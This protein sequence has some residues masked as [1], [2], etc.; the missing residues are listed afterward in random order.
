M[1]TE[2]VEQ[3]KEEPTPVEE[4]PAA[5]KETSAP[6]VTPGSG[7]ESDSDDEV[8]EL[9]EVDPATAQAQ[10]EVWANANKWTSRLGK[11]N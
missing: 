6:I 1:T 9:E 5:P 11:I 4:I 8:P 10:S 3:P 2:I 7:T